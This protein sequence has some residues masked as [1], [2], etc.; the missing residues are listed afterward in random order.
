MIGVVQSGTETYVL[1]SVLV[2]PSA[3]CSPNLSSKCNL[4]VTLPNSKFDETTLLETLSGLPVALRTKS[5]LEPGP[6]ANPDCL[7]HP[8]GLFPALY[9]SALMHFSVP[10]LSQANPRLWV[11]EQAGPSI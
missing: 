6:Q 10:E 4:R 1:I 8:S 5:K 7:T 11:S 3:P 2:G 9:M